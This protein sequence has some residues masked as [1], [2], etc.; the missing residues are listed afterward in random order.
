MTNDYTK[1]NNAVN[2][3]GKLTTGGNVYWS[4][5][6]S[7]P[8]TLK[9]SPPEDL[10]YKGE[11][12]KVDRIDTVGD[13]IHG[14]TELTIKAH[15]VKCYPIG[16]TGCAGLS[17]TVIIDDPVFSKKLKDAFNPYKI[18][19]I[20]VNPKKNATTVIFEDGHVEVVKKS[21]E[22][23]D[24]DIYSVV[25]YA[26]AKYVYGSNSAFKRQIRD[27]IFESLEVRNENI[28]SPR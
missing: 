12:F 22:D 11:R 6:T 17:G 16:T 19:K 24:A 10:F 13:S 25:A 9:Y 1:T 5:S 2:L 23:V 26:V 8:T 27:C 21:P 4:D 14:D 7:I 15:K 18:K 3:V 28:P 20:Q